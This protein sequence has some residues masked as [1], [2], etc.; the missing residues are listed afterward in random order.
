MDPNS[1]EYRMMERAIFE[2][3]ECHPTT[4]SIPR[5][6]AVIAIGEQVI[7]AGRREGSGRHAERAAIESMTDLAKLSEATLY[8]TL[9]PCTPDVR[10]V[11]STCCTNLILQHQIKRVFIGILD[12]NQGV[13][14]KGLWKLQTTGVDVELF[15]PPLASQIH[16]L[17]AAFIRLH[18]SYGIKIVSPQPE[19]RYKLEGG[20]KAVNV[21]GIFDNQPGPDVFAISVAWNQWW[22]QPDNLRIPAP[23]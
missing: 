10:R 4:P 21:S 2:A 12:P 17:N 9:E 13:R 20:Y 18:Q 11:E 22:P 15:P 6:G 23:G 1:T 14:G 7:A 5:V 16:A 3:G 8:T 19:A